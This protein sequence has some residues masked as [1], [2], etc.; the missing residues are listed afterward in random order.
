[1]PAKS[2]YRSIFLADD[3]LLWSRYSYIVLGPP[4]PLLRLGKGGGGEGRG[5]SGN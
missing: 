5:R 2:L 1:M 4:I 3:I